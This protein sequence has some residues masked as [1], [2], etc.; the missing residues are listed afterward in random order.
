MIYG[1]MNLG[2]F[3][4]AIMVE[5]ELGTDDMDKWC[6]LIRKRPFVAVTMAVCLLNLAGLPVPPAGFLAK[7]FVFWSG[8]QMYSAIGYTLVAVGLLT[9]VPA[10]FYYTRV[11]IKMIVREPSELVQALPDRRKKLA[12]SQLGPVLVLVMSVAGL[13]AASTFM[14]SPLMNFSS[15]AVSSLSQPAVIGELPAR[16]R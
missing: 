9:S 15:K 12:D 6:G 10:V 16:T 11:A 13:I 4:A 2:A 3:T 8:I 7:F 5:N 14:V 1:V